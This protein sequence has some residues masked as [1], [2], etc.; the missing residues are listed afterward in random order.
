ME[1]CQIC[2]KGFE[3][4]SASH[5]KTHGITRLEYSSIY[6]EHAYQVRS[7]LVILPSSSNEYAGYAKDMITKRL[8]EL[9]R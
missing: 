3:G 8:H 4:I 2:N 9:H 7:G 1:Y 5:L 6:P